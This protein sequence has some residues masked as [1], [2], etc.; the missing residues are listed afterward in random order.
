[1]DQTVSV[2]KPVRLDTL[3]K[4]KE[5]KQTSWRIIQSMCKEGKAW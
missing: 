4:R 3:R 1:M 2:F 5:K